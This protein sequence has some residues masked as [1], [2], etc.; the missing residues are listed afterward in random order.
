MT[1]LLVGCHA[2]QMYN[3]L[4]AGPPVKSTVCETLRKANFT[5]VSLRSDVSERV[6]CVMFGGSELHVSI[7]R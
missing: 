5:T 6:R 1:S 7:K 2:F 3:S 4:A